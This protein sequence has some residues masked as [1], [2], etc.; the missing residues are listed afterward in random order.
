MEKKHKITKVL[1]DS[2]AWELGIQAGDFL[3]SV[4]GETVEDILGI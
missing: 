4:N 2:I 3:V 1:A